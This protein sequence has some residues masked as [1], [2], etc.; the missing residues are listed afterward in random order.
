MTITHRSDIEGATSTSMEGDLKSIDLASLFQVLK[1]NGREGTLQIDAGSE[2]GKQ[3]V[4]FA[5]AG[6][7]LCHPAADLGEG[8]LGR[9]LRR[10]YLTKEQFAHLEGGADM[11]ERNRIQL[12]LEAD[13]LDAALV[14]DILRELIEEQV[15]DLFFLESASFKFFPEHL[16]AEAFWDA[17]PLPPAFLDVDRIVIEAARRLDEW[18]LVKA[19]V[20]GLGEV[21]RCTRTAVDATELPGGDPRIVYPLIDGERDVSDLIRKTY[22]TKFEV[23]R[24]LVA[25]LDGGFIQPLSATDLEKKADKFLGRNRLRDAIRF[26]TRA[27]EHAGPTANLHVKM[28]HAYEQSKDLAHASLHYREAGDLLRGAERIEEAYRAYTQAVKLLPSDR[29]A[30]ERRLELYIANRRRFRLDRSGIS[31]DATAVI[32]RYAST[33]P[34]RAVDILHRLCL[35]EGDDVPQRSQVIELFLTVGRTEDAIREYERLV[36]WLLT[37]HRLVEARSILKKVL[38]LDHSRADVAAKLREIDEEEHKRTGRRRRLRTLATVLVPMLLLGAAYERYDRSARG[39][40]DILLERVASEGDVATI[41]ELRSF[42]GQYPLSLASFRVPAE[43]RQLTANSDAYQK[44]RVSEEHSRQELAEEYYRQARDWVDKDHLDLAILS[45]G[46]AIEISPMKDWIRREG[47]TAKLDGLRSY[48]DEAEA[49]HQRALEAGASGDWQAE[50]ELLQ[51]LCRRYGKS[52]H[53]NPQS[54][55]L[56]FESRPT[57]ALVSLDGKST[58]E[59]TPAVIRI[60]A[61]QKTHVELQCEGYVAASSDADI[62]SSWPLSFELLKKPTWKTETRGAIT[63]SAVVRDGVV[64]VGSRDAHVYAVDIRLSRV[65]WKRRLSWIGEVE[66]AVV[67]CDERVIAGSN[68]RTLYALRATDG[69]ILWS[70]P[71]DGFVRGAPAA[72]GN[73]LFVCSSTGTVFGIDAD[74]GREIM[75]FRS[76]TPFRGGPAATAQRVVVASE[77]GVISAFSP[78]DASLLFQVDLATPVDATPLLVEDRVYVATRAGTI[79]CL[80]ATNGKE[81]WR[82]GADGA[83]SATPSISETSLFFGTDA[84]TIYEVDATN[85]KQLQ[86]LT[87]GGAVKATPVIDETGLYVGATDGF[88][89][90][91]DRR[92]LGL[93]WRARTSASISAGA[94]LTDGRLVVGSED[95]W[96]YSF[97]P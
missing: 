22:L 20:P 93:R 39:R 27:L 46:K 70:F 82:F 85:G 43:I 38:G 16:E 10:G 80:G 63:A 51:T 7:T 74:T 42:P 64:F 14:S 90:A 36:A 69:T 65:L 84:G 96:L 23:S 29:D 9:C 15:Y 54:V 81:L 87:M 92:P 47:L 62:D 4:Y 61:R 94:V 91:L 52:S 79:H 12:L 5:D 1:G 30:R 75:R 18:G 8:L 53:G 77:H 41:E 59:R 34:D 58:G 73:R 33:D 49:L 45:L 25:L 55:P 17:Y 67:V 56:L 60:D 71:T 13:L 88:F 95:R 37:R 78:T 40:L 6:M 32:G 83:V 21:Y 76:K 72:V 57:G 19:R 2:G 86:S 35:A 3:L 28:A 31:A 11:T 66:S 44:R 26:L 89:Y 50:H 24:A 48:V 97:L 68:D